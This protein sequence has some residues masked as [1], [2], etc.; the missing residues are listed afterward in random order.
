MS[1][2]R[3]KELLPVFQA[4]AEGKQIQLRL[5]ARPGHAHEL[6]QWEDVSQPLWLPACEYRIKPA[7]VECDMW[8]NPAQNQFAMMPLATV[9]DGLYG[10]KKIKMREVIE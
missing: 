4:F 7:P 6:E 8:Y 9:I 1:P 5:G 10:W 2:E 3:A